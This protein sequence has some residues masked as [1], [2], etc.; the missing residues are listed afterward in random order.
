MSQRVCYAHPEC[1]FVGE[2]ILIL[3][4]S[5]L[6]RVDFHQGPQSLSSRPPNLKYSPS[7]S[8]RSIPWKIR[9]G[10]ARYLTCDGMKADGGDVPTASRSSLLSGAEGVEVAA[11]VV[12]VDVFGGFAIG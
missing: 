4:S 8:P 11:I 9:Q 7:V 1:L 3:C 6:H 10:R 12:K 2:S 5:A